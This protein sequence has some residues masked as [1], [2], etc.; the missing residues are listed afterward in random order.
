[1]AWA[2][3]ARGG[4]R[5]SCDGSKPADRRRRW[6]GCAAAGA[7]GRRGRRCGAR[8]PQGSAG[9]ACWARGAARG[10][11][12]GPP[13]PPPPVRV[14]CIAARCGSY[15]GSLASAHLTRAHRSARCGIERQAAR[16]VRGRGGAGG[17][18]LRGPPGASGTRPGARA[19]L[20]GAGAAHG[21]ARRA[22]LRCAAPH[23]AAPRHRRRRARR[24]PLTRVTPAR[25]PHSASSCCGGGTEGARGAAAARGRPQRRAATTPTAA[26]G[27]AQTAPAGAAPAAAS[28]A[29]SNVYNLEPPVKGK[30]SGGWAG[31]G[32]RAGK[33]DP[34]R[35]APAA[36][37]R[38][39]AACRRRVHARPRRPTTPPPPASR[40]RAQV[41]LKTTVGDLDIELWAKEAPKVRPGV[42]CVRWQQGPAQRNG[43]GRVAE[44]APPLPTPR[45]PPRALST[46]TPG[47]PQLCA[48]VPGGV[49]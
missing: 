9:R 42:G 22:A 14:R 11:R 46:I 47:G 5:S 2:A 23:R 29:M 33:P 1:V 30:A 39:P 21:A 7:G 3:R 26:A 44:R 32:G 18:R 27:A 12:A 4:A 16:A 20:R 19:M 49:L 8:G 43:R 24:A 25:P 40:L 17:Q 38:R 41:T 35:G 48:A 28:A 34:A 37:R 45:L 6:R 10:D 31:R 36:G 13:P 15:S